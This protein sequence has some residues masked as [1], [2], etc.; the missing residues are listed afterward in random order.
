MAD[1]SQVLATYDTLVGVALGAGLTYG[2]GALNRRHQESREDAT[3]WYNA[4]R[5]A[6][7]AFLIAASRMSWINPVGEEPDRP[8]KEVVD[9]IVA[10]MEAVRLVGSP[11]VIEAADSL[12]AAV[13]EDLANYAQKFM[14]LAPQWVEATG[15]E[16][17]TLR[18]RLDNAREA[19][20]MPAARK[21]FEETA[22]NDLGHPSP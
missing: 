5:E 12:F 11:R 18:E 2:F 16:A 22:R 21:A 19:G 14:E 6:Y 9:E 3:R 13:G 15:E 20:R 8:P 7:G 10:A 17:A 4:R 1:I